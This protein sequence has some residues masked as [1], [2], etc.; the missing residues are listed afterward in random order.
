MLDKSTSN[1]FNMGMSIDYLYQGKE[2]NLGGFK[3]RRL[4]PF[5]QKRFVGPFVFLDHMGPIQ[6]GNQSR[7]DVR[8]HPHIGLATVTYLFEG[9]AFHSDSLGSQQILTPGAINLMIAG[10]GI[11][12]SERTPQSEILNQSKLHGVQIWLAL[13]RAFEDCEP[14]FHHYSKAAL[15]KLN[16]ADGVQAQLLMGSY[17]QVVSP[18][19]TFSKT[20]FI[21]AL[22][23]KP[24]VFKMNFDCDEIAVYPVEAEI[25]INSKSI[26]VGE[27]AVFNHGETVEFSA[28]AGARFIIIGGQPHPEP[29]FMWWNFV[30][31]E[32]QKIKFAAEKWSAQDFAKVKGESEFIPLPDE[33]Y[34][35]L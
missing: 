16:L 9:Q 11:A 28:R 14:E 1:R 2:K 7:L 27:L 33:S 31:S 35:L 22:V 4:L 32:K 12:H 18:V 10:R 19:K 26:A 34:K 24:S 13:P 6:L 8:P 25:Q 3:V 15:P 29:R 30:S 23:D 20:L 17:E 5:A 21:D